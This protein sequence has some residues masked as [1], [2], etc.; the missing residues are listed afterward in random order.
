MKRQFLA[1]LLLLPLAACEGDSSPTLQS[2]VAGLFGGGGELAVG[3]V[4][5]VTG[6]QAQRLVLSGGSGAAEYLYVPFNGATSADRLAVEVSGTG[7]QPPTGP[8]NPSLS[9]G[10]NRAVDGQAL[11]QDW[12][13]H[14]RLREREIRELTPRMQSA[15]EAFARAPSASRS[16]VAQAASAVGDI[17]TL[18]ASTQ[19]CASPNNRTGRVVAVSERAVIVED[20]ANPAGGFSAEEYRRIAVTFDTLI[21]PVDTRNFGEPGDIDANSRVVIFYTRAVNELTEPNSTSFVGGF[22]FGRD[23]LPR[24]TCATSNAAE[25]FY[26]LAPDPTGAIG[27][28][29]RSKD[30]V[31]RSTLGTV[32]HEFQHLINSSRR[33]YVNNAQ[34]F[35]EVWLNEGL[36]HIAEE[37]QFYQVTP[38]EPRQNID[39]DAILASPQ[40]LEA[41]NT[42]QVANFG[43]YST[44]LE[45]PDTASPRG[46]DNLSTRGS[47]WAFLRYAADQEPGSDRDFFFSLVNS[48]TA[49]VANL[50]QALEADAIDLMQSWTVS[51]YTDDAVPSVSPRYMQPSWNYRSIVPRIRTTFPLKVNTLGATQTTFNL[52]G[53]GGAFVRFGVPAGQRAVI[54]TTTGGAVP[55]ANLRLSVVRIR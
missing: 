48:K 36:S 16:A 38:L 19:A 27:G 2:S 10:L 13:F 50:N 15:R 28:N 42:Y 53:G 49:G 31:L 3:E 9:P 29:V 12:A 20:V 37:L 41:F 6:A 25:I 24:S 32:A 1:S 21:Y 7:V 46:P 39:V 5:S 26:L 23:L 34:V 4:R 8:P 33:L 14:Y 17:V 11:T 44:Y 45:N 35:E 40:I 30:F 54:S 22:F 43:R 51:V 47:I 52:R 18:N 55:P